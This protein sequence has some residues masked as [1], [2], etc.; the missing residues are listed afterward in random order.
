[1][2]SSK[3]ARLKTISS[4]I[5]KNSIVADIGI[6]HGLLTIDLA[7]K[8]SFIYG[9]DI[10]SHALQGAKNL[11]QSEIKKNI[12]LQEKVVLLE[13]NGLRPLIENSYKVSTIILSGLG[14]NS[15]IKILTNS[16]EAQLYK[17]NCN[18]DLSI[19]DKLGVERIILQPWPPNILSTHFLNKTLLSSGWSYYGQ[20]INQ[21]GKYQHLTTCFIKSNNNNNNL[22][23]E[24]IFSLSP[25]AIKNS[26]KL[27]EKEEKNIWID[28][29]NKQRKS[30]IIR[31]KN[32]AKSTNIYAEENGDQEIY[33]NILSTLK[34][35]IENQL[36]YV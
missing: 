11:L 27:L 7:K 23:D 8:A 5:Q 12:T 24:L 30:I 14:P 20:G 25:L 28:Y 6:D 26:Y 13:G 15:V 29:L 18:Y 10:S 32:S 21:H 17:K 35:Q 16:D 33:L 4:F 22:N 34:A 36:K 2:V 9:I 1:M 31:L 3:Y 19:L